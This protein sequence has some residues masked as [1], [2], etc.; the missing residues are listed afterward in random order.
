MTASEHPAAE[1]LVALH[2]DAV[3]D[4]EA[5]ELGAHVARCA[6]CQR[7]LARLDEVTR[8]LA[9]EPATPPAMPRDVAARLDAALGRAAAERATGVTSLAD[10]RTPAAAATHGHRTVRW[11]AAAAAV[12]AVAVGSTIGWQALR[13]SGRPE[14]GVHPRTH[15]HASVTV[16]HPQTTRPPGTGQGGMSGAAEIPVLTASQVPA[17]ARELS[18]QTAPPFS[19]MQS[20]CARPSGDRPNRTVMFRQHL[21]VLAVTPATRTATIYDCATARHVRFTTHY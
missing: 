1:L 10:R 11:L 17:A 2:D 6:E 5:D 13:P 4:A 15:T 12:A 16:P 21:G 8:L 14:A 20:Q 7:L 18:R 3:D 9:D 19:T